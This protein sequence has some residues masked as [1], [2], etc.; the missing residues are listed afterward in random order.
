MPVLSRNS[1]FAFLVQLIIVW[2][3]ITIRNIS[4]FQTASACQK[5]SYLFMEAFIIPKFRTTYSELNLLNCKQKN[6]KLS[7]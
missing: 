4:R 7:V 3:L 5:S 2:W 6:A 1:K